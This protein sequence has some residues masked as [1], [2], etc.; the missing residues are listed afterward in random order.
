MFRLRELESKDLPI[1]NGWR[2]DP[3][4]IS[5]LGAPFRYINL[6][7]EKEWFEGYMKKRGNSVRC[8]ICEEENDEILGLIS[9]MSIDRL[10]QSGQLHIMIG[11]AKNRGRGLGTFAIKSMLHH[12]FYNMNLHRVELLV[13]SSN[14]GAIR[15]YEKLGFVREGVMRKAR[16][17][18][19]VFEDMLMYSMLR[20]EFCEGL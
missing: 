6:A 16:F 14:A 4:V 8:A 20:D 7:T 12:A 13:I 3:E 9:L 17:K 15:L 11:D 18:N 19:G 2:N 1:I 5:L 10:N